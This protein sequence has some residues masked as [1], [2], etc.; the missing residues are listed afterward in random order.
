MYVVVVVC[1]CPC[2]SKR[3]RG[4]KACEGGPGRTGAQAV[5][6]GDAPKGEECMWLCVSLC[7]VFFWHFQ[8]LYMLEAHQ[9]VRSVCGCV[10][11]LVSAK[12]EECM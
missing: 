6:A 3:G 7:R 11:V 1:V 5:Y 10:C 2:V 8:V 4:A 9:K 12:G